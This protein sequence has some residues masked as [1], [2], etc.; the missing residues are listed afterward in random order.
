VDIGS[1]LLDILAVLV[2][3]KLA[4]EVAERLHVP[5]VVGEIAAGLLIGPSVLGLVGPTDTLRVLAELGVILLLLDVGMQMHLRELRAVGRAAGLVAVLG[6]TVATLA[7]TGVA[8]LFGND[9]DT[10]FFVGAAIAAT[11]VG[12]TARVLSDLHA[13]GGVEAR[14]VLAAAIGDD[15]LGL[16]ILAVAV[17][18]V[19][20]GDVAA[21]AVLALIG[22]ALAFLVVITAAGH[23]LAPGLF[24]LVDR[25][26]RHPGTLVA[27]ALAF[28]L[29]FAE[30]AHAAKLAPLIGAFV[31]GLSLA[32]SSQADRIARELKPVGHLLIPV[33]F[34]GIGIDARVGDLG[35]PDVLGLGA[36]LLAV[37]VAAKLIAAAGAL[38]APGD[39]LLIGLGMIP[40]GEVT[41][42]FAAVG[43]REGVLGHDL[44]AAL[45]LVVLATTLLTPPLLRWRVTRHS[46]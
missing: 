19:T 6:V 33:F 9:V 20:E 15:V 27:L 22:V 13:L 8:A 34:L 2:A 42:I 4:A 36:A 30:L 7:G 1:V 10:A 16:V 44:Y 37:A 25:H 17:R 32:G 41:L 12:I 26:S 23:W 43:L 35:R 40:R 21:G 28:T 3:A 18:L 5:A 46:A 11:S 24:H 39:K 38:R 31:A 14:T 45:L 29:A